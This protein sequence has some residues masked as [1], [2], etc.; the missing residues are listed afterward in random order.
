MLSNIHFSLNDTSPNINFPSEINSTDEL[1]AGGLDH[2]RR[3]AVELHLD[4]AHTSGRKALSD[5]L[6]MT[7]PRNT[8]RALYRLWKRYCTLIR[9]GKKSEKV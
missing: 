1:D 9:N 7:S 2:L 6:G 8:L 3:V 4:F 5:F